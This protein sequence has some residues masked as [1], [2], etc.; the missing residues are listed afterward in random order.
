MPDSDKD[1]REKEYAV[2]LALFENLIKSI[3]DEGGQ[4]DL[5]EELMEARADFAIRHAFEGFGISYDEA[6]ELLRNAEDLTNEQQVQRDILVA[7]VDNLVD[8]SVAE[9][10]RVA[11]DI[12]EYQDAI[13]ELD[14]D[15]EEHDE[16]MAILF[17]VCSK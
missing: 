13:E 8:F 14:E 10:F 2:L 3:R 4:W 7:A 17:G 6:L 5:L 9:E 16:L 11:E 12:S 1:K 15:S